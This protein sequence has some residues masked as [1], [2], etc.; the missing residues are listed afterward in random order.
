MRAAT[1][2]RQFRHTRCHRRQYRISRLSLSATE[3]AVAPTLHREKSPVHPMSKSP[4]GL[5]FALGGR[6]GWRS[7]KLVDA[8]GFLIVWC[9]GC[10]YKKR[11]RKAPNGNLL[12]L[13]YPS[14]FLQLRGHRR[15]HTSSAW[16]HCL[17]RHCDNM[18]L[19][20]P[21]FVPRVGSAICQPMV[22]VSNF[23]D[24]GPLQSRPPLAGVPWVRPTAARMMRNSSSRLLALT[25]RS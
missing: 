12:H 24:S 1:R 15:P 13:T 2:R 4:H 16:R 17:L 14:I 3:V 9:R 25:T 8:N 18:F 7:P 20:R 22:G 19:N 21:D 6:S 5:L 23:T 10:S 11:G